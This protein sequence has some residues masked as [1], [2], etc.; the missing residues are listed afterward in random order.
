LGICGALDLELLQAPLDQGPEPLGSF[1]VKPA[2]C[3][4]A[5]DT[6]AG[7]FESIGTAET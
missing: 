2:L 7:T 6:L 5:I 3:Q 4:E 1:I